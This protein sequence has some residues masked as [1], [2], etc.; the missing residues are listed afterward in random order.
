MSEALAATMPKAEVKGGVT[1]YLNLDGALKAAEFY[2]SAFSGMI[3]AAY[4]ADEQ[5]R[6]MHVHLHINGSSVMLSDF[7]AEYGH[8]FQA[9][10]AFSLTL[11]VDDI[12]AWWKRAIAA[13]CTE[14]TAPQTMF[15]GD[16]YA[17]CRDPFGVVWAMNQPA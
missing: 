12:D 14:I 9:P 15:W 11:Q 16:T 1:P 6:T 3:V 2:V 17:Q 8:P 7:Y 4:P 13:G 5:G 10:Q